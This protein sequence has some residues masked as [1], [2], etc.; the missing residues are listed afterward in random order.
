MKTKRPKKMKKTRY[1]EYSFNCKRSEDC[2]N[3]EYCPIFKHTKEFSSLRF[4]NKKEV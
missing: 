1:C 3:G 4:N 2:F